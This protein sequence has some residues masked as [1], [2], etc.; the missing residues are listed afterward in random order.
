MVNAL[1][2]LP[3]V[4]GDLGVKSDNCLLNLSFLHKPYSRLNLTTIITSERLK[5]Y[6]KANHQELEK[7]L[8]SQ[9]RSIQTQ[10]QY[11]DLLQL[12]YNYFG[13]VEGQVNPYIGQEHLEDYL[14]R[15]KTSRLRDDI[16]AL[17]GSASKT[18]TPEDLPEVKN[19]LQAFGALYVL[20]GST[21]GGPHISK[22]LQKQLNKPDTDGL[23]FF[24]SYGDE[25]MAMWERF[26]VVLDRLADNEIDQNV[27]L[28]SADET[29]EKFKFWINKQ[30]KN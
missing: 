20:E 1:I 11:I 30:A 13:A 2:L 22:M 24:N 23:S 28:Q 8:V 18:I 7:L 26:K 16:V 19:L 29:F 6:T 21:L 9:M 27:I 4:S 15:R 3:E 25:T 12:F 17:G 10:E 5:S 14:E